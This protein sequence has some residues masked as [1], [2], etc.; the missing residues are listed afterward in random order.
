M[1]DLDAVLGSLGRLQNGL[2]AGRW[3]PVDVAEAVLARRGSGQAAAW[4]DHVPAADLRAQAARL[5]GEGARDRPLW[6]VPVAVKGNIDV[7]GL[8]TTAGCPGYPTGPASGHAPALVR[9]VEAGAMPVGTTNL[10]QFATG[11]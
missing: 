2:A 9:L 8:P 6:G 7:A 5:A 11:L 10:D 4:I 1:R 3:S